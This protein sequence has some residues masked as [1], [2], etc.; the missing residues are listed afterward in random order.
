MKQLA[1]I[2]FILC[3]CTSIAQGIS[4][5]NSQR[6]AYAALNRPLIIRGMDDARRY[7]TIKDR[8]TDQLHAYVVAQ[9]LELLPRIGAQPAT[10]TAFLRCMQGD[11]PE[12]R[13][14]YLLTNLP[15][16]FTLD[17]DRPAVA[18]GFVLYRG[19]IAIPDLRSYLEVFQEQDGNWKDLGSVGTEFDARA[20]C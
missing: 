11:G 7:P 6:D 4:R 5:C 12:Y 17:G 18:I 9:L 13:N 19:G 3:G 20:C 10:L 15:F 1:L 2:I 16:V 14:L 8:A